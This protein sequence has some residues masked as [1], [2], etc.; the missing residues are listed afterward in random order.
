MRRPLALLTALITALLG[1]GALL[2]APPAGAGESVPE[3]SWAGSAL[4]PGPAVV[5]G[6][7]YRLSGTFRHRFNRPVEIG[8]SASPAG[9]GACAVAPVAMP[10]AATPRAFNVQL[11]I[12]CNGTYT[13]VAT[14]VTTDNN[15]FLGREAVALDRQV[16][17][18]APAPQVTGVVA[19][20]DGRTVAITWDDMR[21]QAPDLDSYIV[22]RKVGDGDFEEVEVVAADEQSLVDD[23]LP[24]AGGEAIYRVLST[25][26]TPRGMVTSQSSE[27]SATTFD[28]APADPGTDAGSGSGDGGSTGSGGGADG[29][30]GSGGSGSGSG[31]AGGGS[32][33]GRRSTA[34]TPPRVFSGTF[35]PPLL[36]PAAETISPPTT[37]DDGYQDAL[38]YG[39]QEEG[40]AEAVL[41]DGAMASITTEG[42]AGR[43]M[44]IPLATAL[45]LAV[46]AFHLR[47][48][49]RAARPT[50]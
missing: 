6:S 47:L 14:A 8:V 35:L 28:A 17:V 7:A 12:P 34:V 20:A 39:Q 2:A 31:S 4:D 45:V 24:S 27:E 26:P 50:G 15:P 18:A 37:V 40:A 19:E 38:P 46:W 1:T 29:G 49:A 36:R 13:L 11:Q 23:G 44:A 42:E 3:G 21:S 10:S 48:L 33:S 9:S 5:D 16:S 30:S 32:G 43:G 25:R 22:E 41:P